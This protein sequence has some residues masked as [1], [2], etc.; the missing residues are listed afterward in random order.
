MRHVLS[1]RALL[2]GIAAAWT[3]P[4]ML[5]AQEAW[6]SRPIRIVNPWPAGGPADL[7]IRPIA[8]KLAEVLG[9]AVVVDNRPGA[10]G[11]IGALHV[12]QSPPDGYT[13]YFAHIGA[14]TISPWVQRLAYDPIRSFTPI[15]H[16]LSQGSLLCT[17][18]GLPVTDLRGLIAHARANPGR[19]NF[20]SIGIASTT[21]L[22]GELFQQAAEVQL[23][24]IPYQG[25]APLVTDMLAD[26]I[27]MSFLGAPAVA[28]HMASGRIRGIAITSARPPRSMPD[29]PTV[30]QVLP[31][32][33]TETWYGM[34]GPAGLRE[35]I[36][37]RLNRELVAIIRSP[38]I[39]DLFVRDT[40]EPI[41][42]TP[43]AFAERIR[44]DLE[45]YGGL[46]RRAGLRPE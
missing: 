34:L 39:T 43:E 31:G 32:F 36:L 45:L 10:N 27:D 4:R 5:H 33:E 38:E 21:H 22:F 23:T 42:S 6:P 25:A 17:R 18:A 15:T 2:G 35:D 20:G 41:A 12:A 30:N 40:Y 11:T 9:Q 28:P 7:I 29:L 46:V 37:R 8:T 19:I 44:R 16:I 1:R 26:R 13:I 3:A 24:H 14:L